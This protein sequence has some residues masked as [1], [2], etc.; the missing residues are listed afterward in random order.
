MALPG[1]RRDALLALAGTFT[2]VDGAGVDLTFLALRGFS[3]RSSFSLSEVSC[4]VSSLRFVL[5][6]MEG[7]LLFRTI[8]IV[9]FVVG[10]VLLRQ[11]ELHFC[12]FTGTYQS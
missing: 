8:R 2:G 1:V 6:T 7:A 3:M 11:L 5:S 9:P 12:K 4:R 10:P